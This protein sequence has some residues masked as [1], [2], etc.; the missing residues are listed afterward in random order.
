MWQ[1]GLFAVGGWEV[2]LERRAG[3]FE[4]ALDRVLGGVEHLG[5]LGGVKAEHVAEYER[6]PLPWWEVLER[7]DEREL[8]R[9]PGLVAA[10]RV[11]VRC[12]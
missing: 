4:C 7:G 1:W 2:L 9:L 8:D 12:R 6:R 3:A 11:R 5:D 10:Q